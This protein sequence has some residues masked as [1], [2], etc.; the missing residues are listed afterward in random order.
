MRTIVRRAGERQALTERQAEVL[1]YIRQH[2]ISN[3]YPPSVREIGEGVGLSSSGTVQHHLE[4]LETKG[5]IFRRGERKTIRILQPGL[6]E[7]PLP[8]VP[9]LGR[10]AAGTPLLA[11]E[12]IEDYVPVPT[13][14]GKLVEGCFAL[15]VV[16]DS[17]VGA[18]ILNGDI[19]IVRPQV[20]AE[21][22][23]IVVARLENQTTSESEVTVKRLVRGPIG[24]WLV[25]ENSAYPAIDATDVPVEGIV[26]GLTRAY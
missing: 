15:R 13:G 10:V 19:V 18:G 17:M 1:A 8:L 21:S 6:P 11:V 23:A 5:Y 22:G 4:E 26:V 14:T 20:E 2:I 12:H 16:G 9:L 24:V 3:G 7:Q 25:P